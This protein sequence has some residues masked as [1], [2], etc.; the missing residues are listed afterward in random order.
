MVARGAASVKRAKY[1]PRRR[2]AEALA[3]PCDSTGASWPVASEPSAKKPYNPCASAGNYSDEGTRRH[4]ACPRAPGPALRLSHA[5]Q[6]TRWAGSA[7]AHGAALHLADQ[8]AACRRAPTAR[9]PVCVRSKAGGMLALRA[10]M[11]RTEVMAQGKRSPGRV[12]PRRM[13]S[14]RHGG[15]GAGVG[16]DRT[17]VPGQEER[18]EGGRGPQC[19]A[20]P[21]LA[22]RDL[23]SCHVRRERLCHRVRI[24]RLN[25]GLGPVA[26]ARAGGAGMGGSQAAVKPRRS[27][28][29]PQC[30]RCRAKH[31]R[32]Y[33]RE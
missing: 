19:K 25:A 2:R 23:P 28:R 31:T 29:C 27:H 11:P 8:R 4:S 24:H 3:C 32:T 18:C 9:P 16:Q 20:S 30:M 33:S 1:G 14:K 15:E 22:P 21:L 12:R 6:A 10:T 13:R 7:S 17:G 26:S 5:R